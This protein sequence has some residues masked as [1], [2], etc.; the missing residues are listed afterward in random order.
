MI[1]T[2]GTRPT[3]HYQ[4]RIIRHRACNRRLFDA[5]LP[6]GAVVRIRCPKCGAMIEIRGTDALPVVAD[7]GQV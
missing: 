6:L 5:Y 3:W 1:A 4:T 2:N 7:V